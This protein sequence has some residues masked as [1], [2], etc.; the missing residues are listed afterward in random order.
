MASVLARAASLGAVAWKMK[1]VQ[2]ESGVQLQPKGFHSVV[3]HYT[4]EFLDA[5]EVGATCCFVC[6]SWCLQGQ[7]DLLWEVFVQRDSLILISLLILIFILPFNFCLVRFS[8]PS[9]SHWCPFD[10]SC[11]CVS[12]AT[13][14]SF[15]F[16]VLS[17]IS[18]GYMSYGHTVCHMS[19]VT[20]HMSHIIIFLFLYFCKVTVTVIFAFSA[21]LYWSNCQFANCQCA[22]ASLHLT[23]ASTSTSTS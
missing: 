1:A 10:R 16:L 17:G 11:V 19:Y 21:N 20:C 22:S 6:K 3:V 18:I 7:N 13:I 14:G 5:R 4:L 23:S 2:G 15:L 12:H 9:Q 8:R